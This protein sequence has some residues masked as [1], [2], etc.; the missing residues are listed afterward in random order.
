[1]STL[2]Y[3]HWKHGRVS[4]QVEEGRFP[5]CLAGAATLYQVGTNGDVWN[6]GRVINGEAR[7]SNP[8]RIGWD[9]RI[10]YAYNDAAID[11]EAQRHQPI[12]QTE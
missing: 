7:D 10:E 12:R 1:M 9:A 3:T 8:V 11:A 5:G 4:V 2:K 6:A